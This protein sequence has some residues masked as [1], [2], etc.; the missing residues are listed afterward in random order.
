MTSPTPLDI[1]TNSGGGLIVPQGHGTLGVRERYVV[2]ERGCHT[3][4]TGPK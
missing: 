3:A 1:L 2:A 4:G